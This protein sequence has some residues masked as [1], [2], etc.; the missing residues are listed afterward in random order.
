[1]REKAHTNTIYTQAHGIHNDHA[2]LLRMNV[3]NYCLPVMDDIIDQ[4]ND[5]QFLSETH[6]WCCEGPEEMRWRW[7]TLTCELQ[8]KANCAGIYLTN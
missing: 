6:T 5:V 1:M 2:N 7:G 8:C 3:E 4:V